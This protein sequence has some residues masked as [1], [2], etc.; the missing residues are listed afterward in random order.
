MENLHAAGVRGFKISVVCTRHNVD[1]LDAFKALADRFGAQLRLTRLRPSGRG[2]D[3]WDELHPQPRPAAAALRLAGRARRGRADRR[4]VL[5][6]RRVRVGA[7]RAQPVRRR[8]GGLPD[9]PG[10]RRVRLP[11]RDPRELPGRQ[12]PVAGRVRRASGGTSE[13]F[14]RAAASRSPA[15]ACGS[16]GAYDA[17][18]GGCMAAKFFTG[19]PLD[20]PDPECVVGHGATALST[21]DRLGAPRPS[22]RPLAPG[23][24]PGR[25]GPCHHRTPPSAAARL[26]REPAGRDR[27]GRMTHS[28][29]TATGSTVDPVGN[30]AETGR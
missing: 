15:G 9:R 5:P 22:R 14:R 18:R 11:V 16:C 4:L 25:P 3:V 23:R 6:P 12:R 10:R 17:C 24:C 26:R 8:P 30:G 1:Q 2:A 20:G 27:R 21:V 29:S 28:T 13:L 7:A 19:L